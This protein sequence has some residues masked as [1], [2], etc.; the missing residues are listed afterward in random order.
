VANRID[1][2]QTHKA[3][4]SIRWLNAT[5]RDYVNPVYSHYTFTT[6]ITEQF[7]KTQN[8]GPLPFTTPLPASRSWTRPLK[9]ALTT[10]S[11]RWQ[12]WFHHT[13]WT[14]RM[15]RA[16]AAYFI[17]P[18]TQRSLEALWATLFRWGTETDV[19]T[20]PVR[21]TFERQGGN[22]TANYWLGGSPHWHFVKA[23]F[24]QEQGAQFSEYL[25]EQRI[26][27]VRRIVE[28]SD[29][30][31]ALVDSAEAYVADCLDKGERD[32]EFE[33]QFELD[34]YAAISAIN[35][36]GWNLYNHENWSVAVGSER[37]FEHY[38]EGSM[39]RVLELAQYPKKEDQFRATLFTPNP[40]EVEVSPRVAEQGV[41]LVG[42]EALK[43]LA[44]KRSSSRRR[45]GEE[46]AVTLPPENKDAKP[47]AVEK[48]E[49][50][51]LPAVN[52]AEK[53]EQPR[54][55]E[56]KTEPKGEETEREGK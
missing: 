22:I 23:N 37:Q 15:E 1:R 31:L 19:H 9:T 34:C 10:F 48:K 5:R 32:L 2:F 44:T 17:L 6:S 20:F 25:R 33:R 18:E 45:N 49:S 7:W 56:D 4:E 26:V 54:Q 35:S 8:L 40:S 14:T 41:S 24:S 46:K 27:H 12:R 11:W 50:V 16:T 21:Y 3:N 29:K 53:K 51:D 13:F 55:A 30:Y 52:K 28:A 47:A 39:R 42:D 43:A 38:T 36:G